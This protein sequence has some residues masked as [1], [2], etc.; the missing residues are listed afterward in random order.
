M[1]LLPSVNS[2]EP[3]YFST[4]ASVQSEGIEYAEPSG[5][6]SAPGKSVPIAVK[7]AFGGAERVAPV[8]RTTSNPS[9]LSLK[10]C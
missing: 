8:S 4:I 10:P 9:G 7:A 6:S 5:L 2:T 1:V 3:A